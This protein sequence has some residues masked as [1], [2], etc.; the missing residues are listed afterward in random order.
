[1]TKRPPAILDGTMT[2]RLT[3]DPEPPMLTEDDIDGCDE[4]DVLVVLVVP[5][6]PA[7]PAVPVVPVGK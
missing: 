4:C 5:I 6:V 3:E 1:M 2:A 7:V